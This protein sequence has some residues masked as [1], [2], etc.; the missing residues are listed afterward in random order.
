MD[1]AIMANKEIMTDGKK[2]T[3]SFCQYAKTKYSNGGKLIGGI[4]LTAAQWRGVAEEEARKA[5]QRAEAYRKQKDDRNQRARDRALRD[6]QQIREGIQKSVAQALEFDRYRQN[7]NR[8]LSLQQMAEFPQRDSDPKKFRLAAGDDHIIKG[9]GYDD[10]DVRAPTFLFNDSADPDYD[11]VQDPPRGVDIQE[12]FDETMYEA[13]RVFVAEK[14]NYLA[15]YNNAEGGRRNATRRRQKGGGGVD[16]ILF[17]TLY[18]LYVYRA[19]YDVELD[20]SADSINLDV[21]RELYEDYPKS[22]IRPNRN[23]TRSRV[24]SK[25]ATGTTGLN[26]YVQSKPSVNMSKLA[27]GSLAT[28]MSSSNRRKQAIYEQTHTRNNFGFGQPI[29][30]G[31]ITRRKK[32][33]HRR[34][35]K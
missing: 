23:N 31:R 33:Y 15:V 9:K 21:L 3:D 26:Y 24:T 30:G 19:Q 28:G 22:E 4:Y 5:R 16:E 35:R 34:T 11:P 27:T 10:D 29:S 17:E 25:P 12:I 7:D 14:P 32:R 13:I 8:K 6:A 20:R 18:T 1:P 2:A